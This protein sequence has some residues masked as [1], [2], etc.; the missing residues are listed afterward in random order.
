[1]G[2]DSMR[3]SASGDLRLSMRPNVMGRFTYGLVAIF[4][5][6]LVAAALLSARQDWRALLMS[7][8]MALQSASLAVEDQV[9]Q[10]FQLLENVVRTLEFSVDGP[11]NEA[12]SRELDRLFRRMQYSLPAI[13]SLSLMDR[14]GV[15]VASSNPLN[16]GLDIGTSLPAGLTSGATSSV[17]LGVAE[18]W[19]GRDFSDGKKSAGQAPEEGQPFFFPVLFQL[20]TKSAEPEPG[21]VLVAFSPEYLLSRV[22]RYLKDEQGTLF[23]ALPDGRLLFSSGRQLAGTTYAGQDWIGRNQADSAYYDTGTNLMAIRR[24][25][26]YPVVVSVELDRGKVWAQWKQGKL[27]FF[28]WIAAAI[29]LALLACALLLWRVRRVEVLQRGQQA[30]AFKLSQALEQSPSG[31]LIT[32]LQGIVEHSNGSYCRL[33]GKPAQDIVGHV[34]PMMD[35]R[36]AEAGQIDALRQALV[37]GRVWVTEQV[38]DGSGKAEVELAVQWSALRNDAGTVTHFMA[39]EHDITSLKQLQRDLA[40]ER[41][42]AQAA[43]KAKSEFLSNMSH[44]IRTPMGGVLGM[45]E[46]ALDEDMSAPARTLVSHARTSAQSLLG[47]LNDILDFSKMEAGKLQLEAARFELHPWLESQMKLHLLQASDKGLSMSFTIK[48]GVP[49]WI[50]SDALRMSQVLNNL[51]SNAIKFTAQGGITLTVSVAEFVDSAAQAVLDF[52]VRDTGCGISEQ[53]MARLFQPFSQANTSTSRVYGGTGLGL[54]ISQRLC[55]AMGGGITAQSTVNQGSSFVARM[56]VGLAQEPEQTG[57]PSLSASGGALPH[58]VADDSGLGMRVLLVED[59]PFNRQMLTAML[60]K[61]GVEATTVINGQEAVDWAAGNDPQSIDLI[62][63]DIQMP[64]MD[65][66]EA[67]RRIRAMPAYDATPIL[68]V[69]A[70]ALQDEKELCLEVG[71][72]D[73]LVK[74]VDLMQIRDKLVKWKGGV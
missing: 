7:R 66:V 33:R 1:M 54:V 56:R 74:P 62:L 24:S 57:A 41:D 73:Y 17:R 69:T 55:E 6:V 72:Q 2:G 48:A 26:R 23:V 20:P 40:R 29:S 21:W 44:E 35:P 47:I 68:A 5:L 38:L 42:R 67:T 32:D 8:Q 51:I 19:A 63:M 58:P 43:T 71:M 49:R 12:S 46:L 11:I 61:L 39:I 27:P 53:E 52:E 28:G 59:H 16:R 10:S 65:G 18:P 70:N 37:Q 25:D 45:T 22:D 31:V 64:I 15:I 9:T 30:E 36:K 34:A 3:S 60:A 13:R 14:R 50:V 4:V